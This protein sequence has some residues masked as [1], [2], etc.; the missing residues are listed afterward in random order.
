MKLRLPKTST[1]IGVWLSLACA[2]HCL[3]TPV[4]LLTFPV[5]GRQLHHPLIE[6]GVLI[7]LIVFGIYSMNHYRKEHHN[8]NLPMGIF[9]VGVALFLVSLLLTSGLH[10]VLA[11]G[12]S[13][14]IAVSH[15]I[16]LSL[17]RA[18]A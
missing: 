10:Q 16:N 4:L 13:L 14:I 2:V 18:V 5:I 6:W 17:K 3:I 1:G 11:I 8:K 9:A 7:T 15:G 12:G